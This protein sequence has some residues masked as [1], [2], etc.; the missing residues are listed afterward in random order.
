MKLHNLETVQDVTSRLAEAKKRLKAVRDQRTN[1]KRGN[2]CKA[3]SINYQNP[4]GG[5]YSISF[6]PG[7]PEFY[8]AIGEVE[9]KLW[10][11]VMA[12]QNRLKAL[13]VEP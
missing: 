1:A 5:Y 2:A 10:C 8:R 13:G 7:T 12:H 9:D 6:E 4:D 3:I 11:Y